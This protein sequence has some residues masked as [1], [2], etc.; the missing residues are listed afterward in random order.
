MFISYY[1][2]FE[3]QIN[4]VYEAPSLNAKIGNR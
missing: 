1:V 4:F 3:E 2:D